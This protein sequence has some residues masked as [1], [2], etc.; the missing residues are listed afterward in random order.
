MVLLARIEEKELNWGTVGYA[1][2]GPSCAEFDF[3]DSRLGREISGGYESLSTVVNFEGYR[4]AP[5]D[6]H[7]WDMLGCI[8]SRC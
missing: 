4:Y 3:S 2:I 7:D 8:A 6:E 1:V 5:L